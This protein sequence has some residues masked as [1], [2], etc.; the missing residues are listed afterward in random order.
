MYSTRPGS[1]IIHVIGTKPTFYQP[2]VSDTREVRR[3]CTKRTLYDKGLTQRVSTAKGPLCRS[4][5]G[6]RVGRLHYKI[7]IPLRGVNLRR[8]FYWEFHF[9]N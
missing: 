1:S 4:V 7:P 5:C 8:Y 2:E 6:N 9:V 3:Q